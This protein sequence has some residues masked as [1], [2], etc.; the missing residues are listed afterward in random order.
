VIVAETRFS[1]APLIEAE[2]IA[3]W[4]ASSAPK[5]DNSPIRFVGKTVPSGS[6]AFCVAEALNQRINTVRIR[7]RRAA[8]YDGTHRSL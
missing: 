7:P 2:L 1:D 6:G 3:V 5:N 4:Q 8:D